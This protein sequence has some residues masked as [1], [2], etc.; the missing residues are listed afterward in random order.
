[1][2]KSRR[3]FTR[4]FKVQAVQLVADQGLSYAE[5]ARRLDLREAQLRTWKSRLTPTAPRPSPD[6]ATPSKPSSPDCAPRTNASS[7]N[8]TS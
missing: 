6:T 5:A 4:E 8:A 3:S 2:P 7:P 1:M